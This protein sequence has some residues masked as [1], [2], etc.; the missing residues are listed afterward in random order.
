MIAYN[1]ETGDVLYLVKDLEDN[2]M[3]LVEKKKT[4]EKK[5]VT[6]NDIDL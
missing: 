5:F 4:G 2:V 6:L 1:E 3:R